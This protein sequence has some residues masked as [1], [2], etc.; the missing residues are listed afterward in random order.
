M[1]G[2][3]LKS[4]D[5][6]SGN[7]VWLTES[8]VN[9]GHKDLIKV[10]PVEGK[11]DIVEADRAGFENPV[12]KISGI[13]NVDE[14]SGTYTINDESNCSKITQDLLFD[15]SKEEDYDIFLKIG[16]GTA[17]I[18]VYVKGEDSANNVDTNTIKVVVRNWNI[19][20]D[21]TSDGG[22]FWRYNIQ[23]VETE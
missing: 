14:L 15:F 21:T 12:I 3:T 17:A 19:I 23:L 1:K 18:P 4:T 22:H 6:N 7:A 2:I 16:T 11:R 9:F 20:I 13:I 10:T 8:T 5:I